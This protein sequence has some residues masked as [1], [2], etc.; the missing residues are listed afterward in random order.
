[1]RQSM[2][3]TLNTDKLFEEVE[4]LWRD[5]PKIAETLM[6][7]LEVVHQDQ[8]TCLKVGDRVMTRYGED[9]V[10]RIEKTLKEDDKYG[11]NVEEV[12]WADNFVVDLSNGHWSYK[13]GIT[14]LGD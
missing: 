6:K 10:I 9:T 2:L 11:T 8:Y 14:A 5:S 13:T 3:I 7:Y 12:S 1:M 4:A